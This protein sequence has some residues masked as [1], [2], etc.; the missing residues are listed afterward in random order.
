MEIQIGGLQTC[1]G[2]LLIS[3]YLQYHDIISTK[4]ELFY[5]KFV[6]IYSWNIFIN[7]NVLFSTNI[8]F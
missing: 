3:I 5:N 7:E 1:F 2:D 4:N 6:Y 8:N